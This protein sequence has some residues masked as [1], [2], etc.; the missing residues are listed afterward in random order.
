MDLP[1]PTPMDPVTSPPLPPEN[2]ASSLHNIGDWP[3][4]WARIKPGQLAIQDDDRR[5]D[6]STFANRVGR[7]AGWLTARGLVAGDRV[8]ILLRNRTGYLEIVFGTAQMGGISIPINL[9]LTPR[10]IAFQIDDG[11]PS[12]LFFESGLS[13]TVEE[14]LALCHHSPEVQVSVGGASDPYEVGLGQATPLGRVS[15]VSAQDPAILMYTSGTTGTPKGALLPHRKALYNSLNAVISFGIQHDDRVLVVAPLFHSLGLQILAMPLLYS[16][17]SLFLQDHFDPTNVWRAVRNEG[18]TYF[19]GVP[20]M[21]QRLYDALSP[22][23]DRHLSR[24]RFVFSAGSAI[25][26]ELIRK[27]SESGIVVL[28]GYG[29]TETSTLCC[30]RAEEA[31]QKAGSVGRPVHHAKIRIILPETV[32]RR[33]AE[34]RDSGVGVTGEIVVRGPITMVGYWERPEATSEILIDDWLR[35]GDLAQRDR[36]GFLTLVGRAREM[37][38]SGGENVYP[39][40]VEAVYRE[41]PGIREVAIVGI[42]HPTWGEVGRA[43]IQLEP[44]FVLDRKIL[45]EWARERIAPFKLPR[46]VVVEKDLPRTASGKIRKH[47]LAK[48]S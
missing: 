10:E 38:I 40:E 4:H 42:P 36:E 47:L 11:R 27:F 32:G 31:L 33:S 28:Q 6:W 25:S 43:H 14:A 34:W 9:R 35:T 7:L 48:R 16:G 46:E 19:G 23:S 1:I 44:G 24:L 29:Q 2:Q 39:A 20:A 8:A 3:N 30:M 15:P 37:L 5:L 45:E 22:G 26:I 17:G 41:Y 13:A 18:I 21:H 12:A